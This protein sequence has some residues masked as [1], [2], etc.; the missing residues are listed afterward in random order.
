MMRVDSEHMERAA[1]RGSVM[2]IH[3]ATFGQEVDLS[4]ISGAD[5][6]SL[7]TQL[8]REAFSLAGR[9]PPTYARA[10][11][12]VRFVPRGRGRIRS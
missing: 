4:P 12:P 1:R 10:N 6:I 5:A 8:S 7:A 11:I 9:E 3:K 2:R